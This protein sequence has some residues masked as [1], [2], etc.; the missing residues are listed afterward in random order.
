LHG[1]VRGRFKKE[2][3]CTSF[4][5]ANG[6]VFFFHAHNAEGREAILSLV[7]FRMRR[8]RWCGL[9]PPSPWDSLWEYN[10]RTYVRAESVPGIFFFT[11][12]TD[13]RLAAWNARA[14]FHLPYSYSQIRATEVGSHFDF[15]HRRGTSESSL[16]LNLESQRLEE[17]PLM[18]WATERY[19]LLTP[20]KDG[21]LRGDVEHA[22]WSLRACELLHA[23]PGLLGLI[24]GALASFR[25][26]GAAWC[27]SLEVGFH[28][29]RRF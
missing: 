23:E 21:F 25:F 18:E 27:P 9:G 15:H 26:A 8:V 19:S 28:P 2:R 20:Y 24:P 6:A 1:S 16:T 17:D 22:K 7:P 29:F 4:F 3:F 14:F 12:E 10:L 5:K 11:L 13:H